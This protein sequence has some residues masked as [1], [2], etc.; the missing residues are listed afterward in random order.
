MIYSLKKFLYYSCFILI[1]SSICYQ[2][3]WKPYPNWAKNIPYSQNLCLITSQHVFFLSN[4]NDHRLVNSPIQIILINL[5]SS[6]SCQ[7]TCSLIDVSE[8]GFYI[9]ADC[10][11][12]VLFLIEFIFFKLI[13]WLH[14]FEYGMLE[15][16]LWCTK[17]TTQ[18]ISYLEWKTALAF[19]I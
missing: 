2:T 11:K 8:T 18:S 9:C 3:T 7:L 6:M 10:L 13:K 15:I 14:F 4:Q 5:F 1:F 17:K 12:R 19:I 16:R